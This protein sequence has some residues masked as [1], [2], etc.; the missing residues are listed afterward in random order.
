MIAN[1]A[2]SWFLLSY[3]RHDRRTAPEG[4]DYIK[5]FFEDLHRDLLQRKPQQGAVG[6]FDDKG[7]Q[8]GNEWEPVLNQA[9]ATCRVLICIYSPAYFDSE[10]CGKEWQVFSDRLNDYLLGHPKGSRKPPLILPVLFNAPEDLPPLPDVAAAIQRDD[11]DYP[12]DYRKN[13]L[14]YLMRR[15]SKKEDYQDFL[16]TL[17]NK[18]I[19]AAMDN[20][21]SD[22][23][24]LP[25]LDLVDAAFACRPVNGL[26]QAQNIA[27][28][29]SNA[30]GASFAHFVYVAGS[31]SEMREE[32]VKKASLDCYGDLAGLD[33]KPYLP[34]VSKEVVY[35]AQQIAA[36]EGFIHLPVTVDTNQN[37]ARLIDEAKRSNRIV[38]I[39]VDTW[40][41][42]LRKYRDLMRQYDDTLFTLNCVVL[43]VWNNKDDDTQNN[44]PALEIG[45]RLAL[46]TVSDIKDER[47]FVHISGSLV[48][49]TK[50]LSI[51]LSKKRQQLNEAAEFAKKIETDEMFTKPE[52]PTP[53]GN[54]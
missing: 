51:T 19:K 24:Q 42:Y 45:V 12:E 10:F 11:I 8:H 30:A 4:E 29:I 14:R 44:R 17:I 27:P 23:R 15:D 34:E 36:D 32:Q 1:V 16:D 52:I 49:F 53:G 35:L 20:P 18:L 7:I 54:G 5:T 31:R 9:L 26:T 25:N 40:T 43:V 46:R 47:Y 39:L 2:V 50:T 48:D 3:A 6:F 37:L 21:L 38:V 28:H 22:L 13:G 41:L 33:W